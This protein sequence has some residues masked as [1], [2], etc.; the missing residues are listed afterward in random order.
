MESG[1]ICVLYLSALSTRL[2]FYHV[3]CVTTTRWG[4]ILCTLHQL[5]AF[6]E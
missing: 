5:C 3:I 6:T 2:C 1:R 4:L